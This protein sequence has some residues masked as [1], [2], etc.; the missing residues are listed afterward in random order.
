[1]RPLTPEAWATIRL[2]LILATIVAFYAI[3]H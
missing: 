3:G 2:A 1:M